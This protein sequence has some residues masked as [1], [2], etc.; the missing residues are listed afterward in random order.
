MECASG[1]RVGRGTCCRSNLR[2]SVVLGLAAALAA[3]AAVASETI[4]YSYDARGRLVAVARSG[5]V[6]NG[7]TA[8]YSYD[9]ADNRT[10]VTV[11]TSGVSHPSFSVSDASAAEGSSLVFTVTRT[12]STTASYSVNYATAD[13]TATAASDYSAVSGT[14]TFAPSETSTTVPV[15]TINDTSVESSEAFYLNLSGASGGATISDPQGVGTISDDDIAP[16]PSFAISDASAIEGGGLTFTV[17]KTG[18]IST[19]FSVS[20][21]TANGTATAGSDYSAV[22]G[23][24]T[25]AAAETSK[26]VTVSTIDDLDVE[27]FEDLHVNLSGA[28]GG[29]TISDAQ[30][31]GTI[32]DNDSSG[33]VCY[34]GPNVVLCP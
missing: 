15:A 25:F 20:Y 33:E 30:A 27:G 29:A 34:D 16:P 23:T 1:M 31:V 7:D 8:S 4:T 6:N 26:T 5:T 22:S 10:N 19:S 18:S 11:T 13:G 21:A 28:T 9:K 3:S 14:L 32:E 2:S 24:I 12:G 17:T